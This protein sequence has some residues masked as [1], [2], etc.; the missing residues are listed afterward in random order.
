MNNNLTTRFP[1]RLVRFCVVGASG[2]LVNMGLLIALTEYFKIRYAVSSLVAIEV[3]ILT[4]FALNNAWTWADRRASSLTERL[5]KY[6]AVAGCTAMAANWFLLIVLSRFF[7]LD[8]RL[9][10]LIGIGA[11]VLLKDPAG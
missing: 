5:L 10:N 3:S 8:Y 2:V 11:G 4:N 6:H 7:G 9:A 1:W